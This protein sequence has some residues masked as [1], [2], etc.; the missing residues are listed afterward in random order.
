MEVKVIKKIYMCHFVPN[1]LQMFYLIV[2]KFNYL[3]HP[4]NKGL[5]FLK[6]S[7]NIPLDHVIMHIFCKIMK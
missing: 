1:I 5:I 7:F 6:N 3:Q 2:K 4:I